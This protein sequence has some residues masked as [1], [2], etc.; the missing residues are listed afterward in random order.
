MLKHGLRA[1]SFFVFMA[2]VAGAS[3]LAAQDVPTPEG[4]WEGA[5]Q[6]PGQVLEIDVDLMED[7]GVWSGDVSI[8]IQET[9]DFPLGGIVVEGLHV[10]FRMEGVPG[11]PIFDGA[12][13]ED[14]Q[15]I[16]GSFSQ[17]GQTFPF[18]MT[19]S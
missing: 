18:S 1:L 6:V 12:L 10:T 17:G 11:D 2:V 9:E 4:H 7:G 3:P 16:S 14:G 15:T 13:S 19:R 8:P 5:I